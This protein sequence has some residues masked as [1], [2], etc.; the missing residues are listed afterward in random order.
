MHQIYH[1]KHQE[2]LS[3]NSV[4]MRNT[5]ARDLPHH[6]AVGAAVAGPGTSKI[7]CAVEIAVRVEHRAPVRVRAVTAAEVVEIDHA[8]LLAAIRQLEY[9]AVIMGAAGRTDPKQ[10]T[11]CVYGYATGWSQASAQTAVSNYHFIRSCGFRNSGLQL[12]H[13]RCFTEVSQGEK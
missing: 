3:L 9:P 7:R 12:W 10:I 2:A 13:R 5:C 11:G 4:L 8:T 6:T 1:R